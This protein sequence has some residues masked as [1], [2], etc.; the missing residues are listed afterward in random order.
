MHTPENG[1]MTNHQNNMKKGGATFVSKK[2]SNENKESI[3][4]IQSGR[5]PAIS[6]GS[7]GLM[8]SQYF[9][10]SGHHNFRHGMQS[11]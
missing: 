11:D 8:Q 2:S 6:S 7:P 10:S 9:G 4:G 3:G 5:S 1:S